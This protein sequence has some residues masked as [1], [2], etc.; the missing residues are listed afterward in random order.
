MSGALDWCAQ[1]NCRKTRYTNSNYRQ[2]I[3]L[4]IRDGNVITFKG[5]TVIYKKYINCKNHVF[6]RIVIIISFQ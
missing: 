3:I 2:Y 5:A 1:G 4:I 6:F